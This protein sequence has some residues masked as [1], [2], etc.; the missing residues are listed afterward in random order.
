LLALLVHDFFL[1]L[2]TE[3]LEEHVACDV[4]VSG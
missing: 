2:E 3:V 4:G 1:I